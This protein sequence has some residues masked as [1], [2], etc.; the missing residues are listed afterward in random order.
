MSFRKCPGLG[1]ATKWSPW[2]WLKSLLCYSQC[3]RQLV[4]KVSCVRS[5]AVDKRRKCIICVLVEVNSGVTDQ[6]TNKY[7]VNKMG[8]NAGPYGTPDLDVVELTHT[9][10]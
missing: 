5:A 3:W 2:S 8:P 7:A 10:R 6:S 1:S 9:F 4:H